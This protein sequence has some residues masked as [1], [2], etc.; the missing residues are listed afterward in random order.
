MPPALAYSLATPP[1][2]ASGV[3]PPINEAAS[4]RWL[5]IW[6]AARPWPG[7]P[8]KKYLLARG[9]ALPPADADLRFAPRMPHCMPHWPS[10][11]ELPAM[12]ALA[13][14]AVTAE[15]RTV[16]LTYLLPTAAAKRT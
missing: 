14:D 6:Q 9:C 12:L 10:R 4:A 2:P 16:H 5:A 15:P 7:T 13:T 8:V 3:H 11:K 1:A